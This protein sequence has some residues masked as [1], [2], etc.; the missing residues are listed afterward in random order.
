MPKEKTNKYNSLN[1]NV[2]PPPIEEGKDSQ[3]TVL[4][5]N[6]NPTQPVEKLSTY[7]IR[8]IR[9]LLT[10]ADADFTDISI[11]D[12]EWLEEALTGTDLNT[13]AHHQQL[14]RERIRQRVNI[15]LD[16]LF[17]KVEAWEDSQTHLCELSQRVKQLWVGEP[18]LD[19]PLTHLQN[20]ACCS[21]V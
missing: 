4:Q 3:A 8:L 1:I 19:P 13:I 6:G 12:R 7:A 17:Q 11:Q 9:R 18:S 20:P 21:A 16:L 14:T 15:A 5:M 2:L 10:I